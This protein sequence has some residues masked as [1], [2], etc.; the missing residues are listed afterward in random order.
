M[1]LS[2]MSLSEL[3]SLQEK[4]REEL[5]IRKEQEKAIQEIKELA[6]QL[7]GIDKWVQRRV[8]A[9]LQCATGTRPE[10]YQGFLYGL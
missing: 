10:C 8:M 5:E 2:K 1:D 9:E 7:R 3:Q 4:I 6:E